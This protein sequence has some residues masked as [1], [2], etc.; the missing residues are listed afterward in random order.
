MLIYES[1][2]GINGV[3]GL[4]V[5]LIFYISFS[6]LALNDPFFQKYECTSQECCSPAQVC[7]QV[8]EVE[9]LDLFNETS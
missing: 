1:R 2:Q 7:H 6:I 9:F 4:L 3:P 8:I 5:C